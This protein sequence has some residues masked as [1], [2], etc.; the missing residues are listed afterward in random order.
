MQKILPDCKLKY[1]KFFIWLL[2]IVCTTPAFPAD[3]IYFSKIGIEQGLS[4]FSVM[5]IY[6]DELGAVWFGTREGVSRYNG[7]SMDVFRPTDNDSPALRGNLVKKICGDGKGKV[8]INTQSGVDVYDLR[9][10]SFSPF[11][12]NPVEVI[13][14]GQERLWFARGNRLYVHQDGGQ[15][16]FYATL[17]ESRSPVT[18]ILPASGGHLYVGTLSSGVFRIDPNRK[19][20]RLLPSC[21]QVS[22]IFEDRRKNIWIG[23]WQDGLFRIDRNG[24]VVRY[25]ADARNPNTISSD[26]VRTVCEDN[27]NCLWIGTE[28]GLDRLVVE[29]GIF[30]H[31]NSD[32]ND[33]R[34][35]S[36][37]SVW[38]LLKDRQGTIWAGTYFGGVNFF[39]PNMHA[40]SHHD[41][42]EGNFRNRPF[43]VICHIIED[44][45][46]NLFLCT[47]G[48]GL[49]YYNPATG[50]YR[51]FPPDGTSPGSLPNYNIKAAWY[52]AGRDELWLGLHLGGLCKMDTRTFRFTLYTDGSPAWKRSDIIRSIQPYREQLLLATF[53]GVFLFDRKT[54]KFSLFSKTLDEKV[55]YCTDIRADSTGNLWI[56]GLGLYHYNVQ[57]QQ[58]RS[59][60]FNPDDDASLS[61]NDVQKI[62]IDGKNRIWLAT[63]G[64]G[65]NRLDDGKNRFVRYDSQTVGLENNYVSNLMQ[66]RFGY[67][68]IT[69]TQGFSMLDVENHQIYNYGIKSGFPLNSVYNGGM[70]L[71]RKGEIVMAGMNGMVSFYEENLPASSLSTSLY[72]VG[73]H[74]NNKLVRPNDETGI[75]KLALPYTQKI[76]LYHEHQILSIE[77]ASDNY[78]SAN[79]LSYRYRLEQDARSWTEL[80]SGVN[81]LNFMNP[82]PGD[83]RL[84]I[85]GISPGD[86]SVVASTGLRITVHPPFY[87]TWYAFLCYVVLAGLGVW[88]YVVFARSK[89]L[90]KTSLAYEKKEKEH[91]EE[92]NQSKLNFFTNISHE[93]R[94]PLTLISGQTDLLLQSPLHAGAHKRVLSIKSNVQNMKNLITELLEF[95]KMEQGHLKIKACRLDFVAFMHEIYL[96]FSEYAGNKRIAFDF[97]CKA[98]SIELWL[99]PLQMQKVFYN[100]LSNAFKYTSEGGCI[101]VEINDFPEQ[102]VIRIVDSGIGINADEMEKIFHCFYQAE[103]GADINVNSPGTG[104]GL[105]FTKSILN[106]HCADIRVESE[107]GAGSVFMVSLPKGHAHFRDDLLAETDDADRLCIAQVEESRDGIETLMPP[108]TGNVPRCS[109]LIVE[110]CDELRL[111]LQSI[112]DPLYRVHVAGDGEEGLQMALEHQPDI[113]LCDVMMP[114]MSG[115]EM[116]TRVKSTFSVCHI[117]VI[118]LTA[119]TAVES[120]IEGLQLGADDYVTKPF[121]IRTLIMRCHNLING[122]RL[123]QE[124]FSKQVDASPRLIATNHLDSEFL[125]KAQAVIERDMANPA[126]DVQF[127]SREMA[128]GRTKLFSK[129]KGITG[130]TPNDFILTIRLKKAA[131]L[132][133]GHPE[134]NVSDVCYET[135][136]SSPKYFTKCFREHFGISPSAFRK[137][138]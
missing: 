45:H 113:I 91:L 120:T 5:S 43:P 75:L 22:D 63:N 60:S 48:S 57:T 76:D 34:H 58:L 7:S 40:F 51:H 77:F 25:R 98:E 10:S 134:Y 73:L 80:P 16:V 38:S 114:R 122:R 72:L 17:D 32:E 95:R 116:C 110:D 65:V 3:D 94:T 42:H 14:G 44:K 68:V 130:Q 9:T 47:E 46:G 89:L 82:T 13:A 69:T 124:K 103:N 36:N 112:F 26:F 93:F 8:Y 56:A 70:C 33:V 118:L 104:I 84:A 64:G 28:K 37:K 52:D 53:S 12:D 21:S 50:S 119:K 74:V 101:R 67:L 90:L 55:N 23:T 19:I 39:N 11:L 92:V 105:A 29:S 49:I 102:A 2:A 27:D 99:D 20:K 62:F 126:F 96:S 137:E 66:S 24:D 138:I 1:F 83:Y 78:L 79:R 86:G 61:S 81:R 131:A 109:M 108:A 31:Y 125:E 100:L 127:L 88:R 133:T 129:I 35:L 135:G 123:L 97:D 121:N 59:W 18:A 30:R 115:F 136:F 107:V 87:R 54:E 41:L 4:Q 132:L 111:L 117:P 106:V 6:K 128:L 85:E 71:T 15:S